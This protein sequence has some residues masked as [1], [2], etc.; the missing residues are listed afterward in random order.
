MTRESAEVVIVGGGALGTSVA[1]HLTGLGVTDVALL[2]RDQLGSG[3]TG[4]SAGGFRLQFADELNVRI[5][6]RSI[7]E[8]ERLEDIG[9]RQVGYLFLL[10]SEADLAEF[11]AALAL[12]QS[13]GVPSRELS[14]DEAVALVPQL[15]AEGLVGATFCPLDGYA[16]PESVVQAYAQAAAARGV[17]IRQGEPVTA[18]RRRGGA[19]EAVETPARRI[20]TGTVVCAAGAWSGE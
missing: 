5:A 13:L 15:S 9:F 20:A 3:S 19:I 2:E 6:L 12:Q 8:L 7:A 11:R 4:K 14:V 18:I 17:R 16:S 10:D 1:Y